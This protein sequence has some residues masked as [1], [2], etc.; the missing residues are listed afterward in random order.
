MLLQDEHEWIANAATS[1]MLGGDILWQAMCAEW[2]TG[3]VT[4]EEAKKIVQAVEDVMGD[5]PLSRPH[6]PIGRREF[7]TSTDSSGNLLLFEQ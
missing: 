7:S 3:C 1:L 2:A 4:A 5:I 6:Q